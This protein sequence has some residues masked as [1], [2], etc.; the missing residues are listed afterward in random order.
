MRA[1]SCMILLTLLSMSGTGCALFKKNTN[2]SPAPAPGGPA[3][4]K[5][6]GANDPLLNSNLPTLPAFP[7]NP[8]PTTTAP[9]S[10][11]DSTLAGTVVDA[12][13]RPVPNAYIR[14]VNL[15][16][17]APGAP[18]DVAA[19]GTGHFIIQGLK[20]GSPYQLIA[21]TKN[22]EKMLAGT[23]LTTAPNTRVAIMIREDLGNSNTPP[24]PEAPAAP[25]PADADKN[26]GQAAKPTP[27]A[28]LF[29][30]LFGLGKKPAAEPNLPTTMNVPAPPSDPAFIPG[31]GEL[32]KDRPPLLQIPNKLPNRPHG[33]S[34][35]DT[36]PTRMPSCVLVGNHLENFALKDSKGQAW[37]Y[38]K[39]A[40]GKLVLLDFWGTYCFYCRDSMPTLNRLQQQYGVRGLEVIGIALEAGKDEKKEAEAVNKFCSSMQLSYRQLMGRVG[41]FD[42]GKSFRIEGVPTIILL[43]EQGDIIWS[44]TGRP[45]AS[46]LAALER[47]IQNRLNNR[48][49]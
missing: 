28:G 21:R 20:P 44:H 10:T 26:G 36:G 29:E 17:K 40:N 11:G 37:E 14:W 3:P 23:V 6:P 4:V 41:S 30:P 24:L 46:L 2:G 43:S 8:K 19:N 48:P 12:N 49:F 25:V 22:G 27:K 34:K 38:K 9:T 45:D 16:E 1:I 13:F 32:P 39:H 33:E 15:E 42:L 47:T 31:I 7:A 5:F 35:L 18:I